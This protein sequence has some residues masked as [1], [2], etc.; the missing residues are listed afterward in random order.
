M[1][2]KNPWLASLFSLIVP[3]LGYLY[4]GH[5][6]KGILFILLFWPA[7]FLLRIIAIFPGLF[8]LYTFTVGAFFV[9]NIIHPFILIKKN[10]VFHASYQRWYT[11]TVIIAMQI[12]FM[13]FG[14]SYF[15]KAS[16]VTF[17]RLPTPSMDP[18]IQQGESVV[19]KKV[20]AWKRGD[21]IVF[22]FP[23]DTNI[24]YCKRCVAE[25]GDLLEIKESKV[26]INGKLQDRP[27]KMNF[28]YLLLTDEALS[29]K[30][31]EKLGVHEYFQVN[32]GY[33]V[34]TSPANVRFLSLT[35]GVKSITPAF[36]PKGEPEP[37]VF[38]QNSFINWNRDYFGPIYIPKKG[39]NIPLDSASGIIYSTYIERECGA[40]LEIRKEGCFLNNEKIN[41]YTFKQDYY[42]VMGDNRHNSFDSRYW[43]FV[44][45]TYVVSKVLYISLSSDENRKNL[46]LE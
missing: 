8:T 17:M 4:I 19:C 38:P 12:A 35:T 9:F 16:Y 28:S 30:N 44:P 34:F 15:D 5:L 6:K 13:R 11:Y 29:K 27:D 7:T 24:L 31:F 23:A 14:F 3:G 33:R 43:G 22:K 2:Q 45:E 25:P 26:Y 37:M 32:G 20:S 1:K 46:S 39:A 10:K 40:P 42:F 18:T 21:V 41:S 36:N